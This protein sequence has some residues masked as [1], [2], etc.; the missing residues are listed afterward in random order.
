MGSRPVQLR[1]RSSN[2]L[3]VERVWPRCAIDTTMFMQ[4]P[5]SIGTAFTGCKLL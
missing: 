2:S 5:L 4:N 1:R 3:S